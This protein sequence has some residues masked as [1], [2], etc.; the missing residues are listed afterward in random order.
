LG[1][2][3]VIEEK[4]KK[5]VFLLEKISRLLRARLTSEKKNFYNKN[6][7]TFWWF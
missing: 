5:E 1:F 2:R 4:N 3:E 7:R 6:D